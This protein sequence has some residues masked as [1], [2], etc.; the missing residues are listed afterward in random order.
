MRYLGVI[1]INN[2]KIKQIILTILLTISTLSA[3]NVNW[4]SNMDVAIEKA[5][6][7]QTPILVFVYSD[8]CHY[9]SQSIEVFKDERI[10][11]ILS[12][13]DK[14]TIV[15]VNKNNKKDIAKYQLNTQLYP[16][17]FILSSSGERISEPFKGFM[18]AEILNEM[19]VS[20]LSWYE[21]L[22]NTPFHQ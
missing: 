12:R 22:L 7:T 19:L 9:C 3:S 14:L 8:T 17:Y 1:W 11:N 5:T 2:M 4:L 18:D 10:K 21:E 15:A 6:E 20:L 13:K 16:T